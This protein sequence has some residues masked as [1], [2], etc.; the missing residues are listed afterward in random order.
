MPVIDHIMKPEVRNGK[1]SYTLDLTW[2][3]VGLTCILGLL[4]LALFEGMSWWVVTSP[5]WF[6]P[7]LIIGLFAAIVIIFV[8]IT[9]G[10]WLC[11]K[12][13]PVKWTRKLKKR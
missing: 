5:L 13:S 1:V 7:A 6:L 12:P 11:G 9:V 3:M 2:P 4:K 10:F 8:V